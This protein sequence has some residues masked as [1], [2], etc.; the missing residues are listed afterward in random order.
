MLI[1]QGESVYNNTLPLFRQMAELASTDPRLYSI[2]LQGMSQTFSIMQA[3]DRDGVGTGT[4]GNGI[5]Q[6][7]VDRAQKCK[8]LKQNTSPNKRG[9]K[10]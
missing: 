1:R 5:S 4:T 10:K 6:P 7:T 2:F 9:K 8:R 3:E